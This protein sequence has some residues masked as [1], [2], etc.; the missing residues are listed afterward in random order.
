MLEVFG[1]SLKE[2]DRRYQITRKFLEDKGLDALI[3]FPHHR[4]GDYYLSNL[5]LVPDGNTVIFPLRGEPVLH[6]WF[7]AQFTNILER[8]ARGMDVWI[9]DIRGGGTLS[10]FVIS[11]LKEKG[12][13][14]GNIGVIGLGLVGPWALEGFVPYS[15]WIAIEREFPN[16]KFV[17]V[18][19][20]YSFI[21]LEKSEEELQL[22]ERAAK[23]GNEA[24][25]QMM[26]EV[27]PGV[28]EIDVYAAGM[29]VYNRNGVRAEW[30][31]IQSG[32]A[33]SAWGQPWWLTTAEPARIIQNGDIV[34]AELFPMF[35]MLECQ[36]Q[37]CVG[38]GDI[39]PENEKAAEIARSSYVR[40]LETIRPGITFGEVCEAMSEPF[41]GVEGAWNLTPLI[42]SLNPL[43]VVSKM[44]VG[45]EK[46]L[47]G[48]RKYP[49]AKGVDQVIGADLVIK[50][51]MVFT[52]EPNCHFGSHRVNMGGT[53]IITENGVKELNPISNNILRK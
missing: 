46:Y 53:V 30:M 48:V 40:G 35:G 1:P 52:L 38:V 49:Y 41:Q 5:R 36:I 23:V 25:K 42:H 43:V 20:P 16:A 2:R 21:M 33:N 31:I 10:Q 29:D 6:N 28:S 12:L 22:I 15:T 39:G 47:P 44:A 3:M 24:C 4:E 37:M 19:L 34:M 45:V 9:P 18:G 50:P 51:N 7:T 14:K 26:A 8:E 32:H 13:E 17:E 27:K 11:V